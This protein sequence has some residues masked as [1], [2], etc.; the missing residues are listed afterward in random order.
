MLIVLSEIWHKKLQ[1]LF[2]L[3]MSITFNIKR[4]GHA[5]FAC[6]CVWNFT[7]LFLC[8][9]VQVECDAPLKH[10]H[11]LTMMLILDLIA[12]RRHAVELSE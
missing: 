8:L 10:G 1:E 4:F 2:Y 5:V 6:A 11:F 3:K 9:Q 7:Y 12:S